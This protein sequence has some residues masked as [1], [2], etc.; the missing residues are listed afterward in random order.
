MLTYGATIKKE[1]YLPPFK[2]RHGDQLRHLAV[3]Y[4]DR[5]RSAQAVGRLYDES[6]RIEALARDLGMS[7]SSLH[8]K[9]KAVTNAKPLQ[10]QKRLGVQEARRLLLS[11]E[12]NASTAG[13][14]V[15]YDDPS[16]FIREYKRLFGD[17][18]MRDVQQLRETK[19]TVSAYWLPGSC[20][21]PKLTMHF[22]PDCSERKSREAR[23]PRVFP[24]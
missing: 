11:E 20:R 19:A 22:V 14:R 15:G 9:F 13:Y 7:T 5:R 21:M 16:H 12:L 3:L 24:S 23:L 6:I 1:D 4:G 18:P 8:R 2:G 17:P 10:F